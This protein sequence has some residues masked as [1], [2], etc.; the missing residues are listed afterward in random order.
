MI[1]NMHTPGYNPL[2]VAATIPDMIPTRETSLIPDRLL[3]QWHITDRCNARC[4]HCYGNTA[5]SGQESSPESL[6]HVLD[7]FLGL[8]DTLDSRRPAGRTGAQVTIT[9]GE[10]FMHANC[11]DLLDTLSM[12]KKRLG[13]AILT[14]GTMIDDRLARY[15]GLL[16]P[17]FTQVSLD[18]DRLTHD[19][20]RGA[21][22]FDRVCEGV[23]LLVKRNVRTII[24]FTA[25]AANYRQFDAVC[26]TGRRLRVKAVWTDRFVPVGSAASQ[27]NLTLT[28]EQTRE[29]VQ[30]IRARQRTGISRWFSRTRIAS[31]RALQFL[32]GR[33]PTP[34]AC[35]AGHS[36]IT[37]MPN[38]D[39]M[40]C[41][42]MPTV[43]G[44]VFETDLTTLYLTSP[45]LLALRNS[46]GA[47]KGCETCPHSTTCRGGLRCLSAAIH[48]NPFTRDPGCW[49][50]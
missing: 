46:T 25:S 33:S 4:L 21:G 1:R 50:P 44:N 11:L 5:A 39:L 7:Q 12:H 24:S 37:I 17:A 49:L 2:P 40:P 41:R 43:A 16:G 29:Y 38:G 35:T 19:S 6:S 15:L 8:L 32:G 27:S 18:G 20:I 10:P 26:A 47:A 48:N 34:Y 22:N 3:L 14:N 36:L 42:R 13:I 30:G 28:P 23:R 31:H 45:Q 9:G